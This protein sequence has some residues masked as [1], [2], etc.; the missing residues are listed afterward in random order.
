[1][2]G[3]ARIADNQRGIIRAIPTT[4][5]L[6][7]LRREDRA[8]PCTTTDAERHLASTRPTIFSRNLAN[9][10]K[11]KKKKIFKILPKMEQKLLLTRKK[12][13]QE[14]KGQTNETK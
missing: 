5:R 7:A 12:E 4:P 14:R 3:T 1:M 11:F 6:T 13:F 2:N 9:K 8:T 10:K